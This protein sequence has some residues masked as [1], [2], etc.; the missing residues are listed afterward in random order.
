MTTRAAPC[1]VLRAV[2]LAYTLQDAATGQTVKDLIGKV[3][4]NS[5]DEEAFLNQLQIAL[6]SP[7]QPHLLGLNYSRQYMY[8]RI[9]DFVLRVA[10][11]SGS[12]INTICVILMFLILSI[13]M[14]PEAIAVTH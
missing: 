13:C 8:I 5:I 7:P 1:T 11:F 6:K 12:S 14:G 2:T 3:M 4:T 10:G 9:R